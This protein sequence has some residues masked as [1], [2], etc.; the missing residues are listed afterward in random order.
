MPALPDNNTETYNEHLE[1][2]YQNLKNLVYKYDEAISALLSGNHQSYQLDTGQSMQRVTR[3]DLA[4]LQNR[5]DQADTRLATL[6]VR[7]GY[8]KGTKQGVPYW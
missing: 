6:A 7:L 2:E 5:R 4:E 8:S 3:L 1:N